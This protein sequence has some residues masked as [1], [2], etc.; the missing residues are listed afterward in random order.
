MPVRRRALLLH[1]MA[2]ALVAV[3][4]LAPADARTRRHAATRTRT[5]A[6]PRAVPKPLVAIDPG[7]GG[8]DP[9][10]IGLSG[11]QEKRVV[12]LLGQELRRRL[13]ASGRYRVVMTRTSDVFIP[14]E[15]RVAIARQHRAKLLISLHAN[16]ARDRSASGACVYRFAYSASNAEA[17]ATARWENSADRFESPAFRH[18]SP[19]ITE[20][21][22][23]LMRRATW[24]HSAE[25]QT[26]MVDDLDDHVS[27]RQVAAR[28]ARF[29]VLSAPDI[30]SVLIETGFLTNRG[31]E[32]LLTS[33]AH[34]EVLVQAMGRAVDR[35]FALSGASIG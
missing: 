30:P 22:I 32:K 4:A 8:K 31:D 18:A 23:S 20:I 3:P 10:C 17:A 19:E 24:H 25:L 27:M 35:Y 33:K 13:L 15:E 28:H 21:L 14:L 6:S 34:R 11:T 26:F 16:A 12:L 29:V 2:A 7:H 9:G 1:A 5:H